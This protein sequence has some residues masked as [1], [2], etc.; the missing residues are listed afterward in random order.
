MAT[1]SNQLN[2]ERWNLLISLKKSVSPL[3]DCLAFIWL[4]LTIYELAYGL[5][6]AL[7]T[8]SGVIWCIFVLYFFIELILAPEKKVY[9][10]HNWLTAISLFLP[11]FRIFRFLRIFRYLRILR[12]LTL[13]KILSSVNRGM[14]ALSKTLTTKVFIYVLSLSIIVVLSGAAGI[15]NFE[16]EANYFQ[17]FGSALWWSAMMVTTMGSDFF[18]K[19]AEG[20]VLAFL[21]ALY[22]FA[23]FGY[24]AAT[25][26]SY[27][28]SKVQK[29]EK[30]GNLEQEIQE[31][32]AETRE[33]KAMI[34]EILSKK[35][36]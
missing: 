13:V 31:L 30:K 32:R 4:A 8:I 7:E 36:L 5:P 25:F 28:I 9:L 18:P 20:R 2:R 34:Q 24:V 19:S 6:L 21:L 33:L 10:K 14:R 27:L 22:G 15:L 23:I 11:A 16:K 29:K 26:S 17:G 1:S 3:M 12:S 35:P